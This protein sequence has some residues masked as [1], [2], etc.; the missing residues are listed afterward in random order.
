ML[1][2]PMRTEHGLEIHVRR[3][4]GLSDAHVAQIG[5]DPFADLAA[6]ALKSVHAATNWRKRPSR[7]YWTAAV[8]TVLTC[9]VGMM[10]SPRFVFC[11]RAARPRKT[12]QANTS[13]RPVAVAR[14]QSGDV[15]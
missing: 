13:A 5:E 1:R 2:E 6:A 4:V 3:Q 7:S 15:L 11:L 12:E 9:G 10:K 8:V 14:M